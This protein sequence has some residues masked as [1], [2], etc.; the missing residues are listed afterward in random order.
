MSANTEDSPSL[1][2]SLVNTAGLSPDIPVDSLPEFEYGDKLAKDNIRLL[3]CDTEEVAQ[4]EVGDWKLGC[5]SLSSWRGRYIAL[6]YTWGS[7]SKTRNIRSNGLSLSVTENVY[8]ALENIHSPFG[9]GRAYRGSPTLWVDAICINQEDLEERAEQVKLMRDIYS[10][11]FRTIIW[12]P[13]RQDST[14]D[15]VTNVDKAFKSMVMLVEAYQLAEFKQML[16]QGRLSFDTLNHMTIG[17]QA[18]KVLFPDREGVKTFFSQ[19]WFERIWI[20]QEV[21]VSTTTMV[22]D[23][24][25]FAEWGFFSDVAEIVHGLGGLNPV[26][27][28]DSG[29]VQAGDTLVRNV[30]RLEGFRTGFEE[31]KVV[32]LLE[33]L[34][35]TANFQSTEALDRVY[36]L[37]GLVTEEGDHE[38]VSSLV[39]YTMSPYILY[40]NV[41]VN[42]ILCHKTL[43]ILHLVA[44]VMLDPAGKWLSLVP[45]LAISDNHRRGIGVLRGRDS[46]IYHSSLETEPCIRIDG[47]AP[48]PGRQIMLTDTNQVSLGGFVMDSVHRV[49]DMLWCA[50]MITTP[51]ITWLD[52]ALSSPGERFIPGGVMRRHLVYLASQRKLVKELSI[53]SGV[54]VRWIH[55]PLPENIDPDILKVCTP[56]KFKQH[57][58]SQTAKHQGGPSA[59]PLPQAGSGGEPGGEESTQNIPQQPGHNSDH[60]TTT[61]PAKKQQP[62]F[63]FNSSASVGAGDPYSVHKI[64]YGEAFWRTLLANRDPRNPEGTTKP[65]ADFGARFFQPWFEVV[66]GDDGVNMNRGWARKYYQ[67]H[68]NL[69][70]K[71]VT[72]FSKWVENAS[73]GRR[74]FRTGRGYIGTGPESIQ[75]GDLICVLYG[76]QAPF[77]LREEDGGYRLLGACYVHGFMDGEGMTMGFEEKV[78][79]FV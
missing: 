12:L 22:F 35:A 34:K 13:F 43:D 7:S 77:A 44:P 69:G 15:E 79:T 10:H 48:E 74:L 6:S 42:H 17:G 18:I 41:V 56:L 61:T 1:H 63:N 72:M 3:V 24:K 55:G 30:L 46:W 19:P 40:L 8:G 33:L 39:D 51:V 16:H 58:P 65:D 11:A 23:G 31:A 70:E 37:L 71:P 50:G 9:P 25:F 53:T 62:V 36:G 54:E 14:E 52:V 57:P 66:L 20:C 28:I 38:M 47:K 59:L 29:K 73:L 21:A 68:S 49:G 5:G 27:V 64:T 2:I 45:N 60:S 4:G 67:E 32:G 76:R 78:F 75:E 26:T